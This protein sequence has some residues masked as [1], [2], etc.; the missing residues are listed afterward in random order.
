MI[1][2]LVTLVAFTTTYL[3]KNIWNFGI[4]TRNFWK[5]L[6]ACAVKGK[7]GYVFCFV[8]KF[9]HTFTHASDTNVKVLPVVPKSGWSLRSPWAYTRL[10]LWHASPSCTT[11]TRWGV[12]LCV[13]S[14]SP[15]CCY[16][17]YFYY[18]P[19]CFFDLHVL[20]NKKK[21]ISTIR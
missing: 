7:V 9:Y 11:W 19:N 15:Y 2:F 10:Q 21:T 14:S 13:A 20:C 4:S 18:H 5:I 1:P 12:S 16:L 17:D 3:R 8:F 6:I